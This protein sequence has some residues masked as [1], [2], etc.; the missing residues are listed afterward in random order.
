MRIGGSWPPVR[1]R[2]RRGLPRVEGVEVRPIRGIKGR[3]PA[4][5][6]VAL[7]ELRHCVPNKVA[8]E[9]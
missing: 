4:I 1:G 2:S 5:Q 6:E 3:L 9:I 7:L 8:D